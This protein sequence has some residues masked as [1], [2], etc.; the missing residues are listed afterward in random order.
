MIKNLSEN[1]AETAAVH[2]GTR[3]WTVHHNTDIWAHTAPVGNYG[4]GDPAWALWQMG[5]IWLTQHLWEHYAFSGD[6]AYLRDFAYPILKEAAFFALDWLIEDSS[7]YLVTSPSTSPEHKF[8]TPEGTAAISEGATMDISLIWELFTNSIEAAHILGVDSEFREELIQKRD[9]LLPLQIGRYGQLQEWSKDFED[10][11]VFHR[12]T[13]HL[14]GVHPG[15]QLSERDTPELFAAA[16]TSLE[17]RGDESTGWSLGWRVALWSRFG[18]GDRALELLSNMLRLVKD[19]E[20]ERYE[21]GG[22]YASLLGAHPPFQIDGNFAATAG[23]AEM[24]LQSHRSTLMLLPALPDAW[25]AGEVRGLRAR[26]G[27]EVSIRWE[28]GSLEEAEI[29]S[30]SG[31]RCSVSAGSEAKLTV[32]HGDIEV[33]IQRADDGTISF[34]TDTGTT[35]RLVKQPYA[36]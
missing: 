35:Y 28:N 17:R 26:G 20:T 34:S 32:Y 6:E 21:Q 15:R 3:G 7:G 29:T 23:I 27:F 4:E 36:G 33:P 8:R 2:Y 14:I 19:G 16:R 13:S 10:E 1:G 31:H 25:Q 24:L 22:V 30:C 12:H 11:D 9:R 18:E 5:G